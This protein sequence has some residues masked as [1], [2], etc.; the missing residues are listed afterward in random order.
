MTI[1]ELALAAAD[2]PAM[3]G[4]FLALPPVLALVAMLFGRDPVGAG[5]RRYLFAALVYLVCIPGVMAAVITAYALLFDGTSIL[6]L[7][8]LVYFGPIVS[9][10]LTLMLIARTTPL[11]RV[12]GFGRIG[13]FMLM[14]G[15]AFFVAFILQRMR[16]WVVFAGGLGSLLVLGLVLF[17]AIRLGAKKAFGSRDERRRRP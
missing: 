7:D 4:T 1:E 3:I 15:A 14:L 8:I 17:V 5:P 9:M 13:G 12:P 11:E 2:Q 16:I 10:A 6:S